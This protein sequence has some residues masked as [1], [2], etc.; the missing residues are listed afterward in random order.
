MAY[1]ILLSC[2]DVRAG[3]N[4]CIIPNIEAPLK[5]ASH[6]NIFSFTSSS[7]RPL[8]IIYERF[9]IRLYVFPPEAP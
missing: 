6:K 7:L 3:P 4:Q 1:F 5:A 9:I 2:G 8:G